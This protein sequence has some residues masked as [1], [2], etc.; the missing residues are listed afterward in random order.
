M[1]QIFLV[2]TIVLTTMLVGCGGGSGSTSSSPSGTTLAD[3]SPEVANAGP[4]QTVTAGA[5]PI[6]DGSASTA[7]AG[8]GANVHEIARLEIA[9]GFGNVLEGHAGPW[10]ARPAP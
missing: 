6:L 9:D 5:S 4:A 2:G 8:A 1:R 7:N 10:G 3:T